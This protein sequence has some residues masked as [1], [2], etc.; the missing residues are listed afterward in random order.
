MKISARPCKLLA[1][2]STLLLPVTVPLHAAIYTGGTGNWSVG[3]NWDTGT[4]PDG[5]GAVVS[6][7]GSGTVTV[8]QDLSSVTVGTISLTGNSVFT[9]STGLNGMILN[10]DGTGSGVAVIENA[11]TTTGARLAITSG[12]S[13]SY[14]QIADDLQIKQSNANS[15]ASAASGN[16]AIQIVERIIGTGSIT[17]S[18]VLNDLNYGTI[19]MGG[20]TTTAGTYTG[21]ITVAK[22]ALSWTSN[23]A[24]GST[25]GIT[26]GS[27]GGGDVSFVSNNTAAT[28]AAAITV[29]SG[30]GGTT[31]LGSTLA[32][33]N[34]NFSGSLT[35]NQNLTVISQMTTADTAGVAIT[36]AI[37]G[38][39]GLQINGTVKSSGSNIDTAGIVKLSGTN[40]FTG[41]TRVYKGSL[42]LGAASGTNSLALQNSTLNLAS[43]DTGTVGF[44]LTNSTTITSATLGGLSGTRDL[45][46]QNIATTSAAVALSVGKNNSDTTYSGALTGSGSL[47]KIG[48]GTLTLNGQ[49]TYTGATTISA[50]TLLL[51]TGSSIASSSSVKVNSASAKLAGTGLA[52]AIT[53]SAG[54]ISPGNGGI[55][56]LS[57]SS[58]A[59]TG[60]AALVFDLSTTGNTSDLLALSGALTKVGSGSYTFDFTGGLAGQVYTLLTFGSSSG[61][62]S[63]DF[64][65]TGLDGTFSLSGSS[66]TFTVVPE[67]ATWT[68]V[69]AGLCCTI[70]LRR[71]RR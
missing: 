59:W 39:G 14:L 63:S 17:F 18:N 68:L 47:T 24:F 22:G 30:T 32:T 58:L 12:L 62:S 53:L 51:G 50:G 23:A 64:S 60:G 52:S 56:T 46:L 34:Q 29:A 67:P 38:A 16:Y 71:R 40:T 36:G 26:L 2:V 48:T 13:P 20:G 11:A 5:I 49:S 54:S 4:Y 55:G 37:S 33:G 25:S 8:T 1:A 10:Q 9:I 15:T 69:V 3:T 35:L 42:L 65:T 28:V 43:G 41:D 7:T 61:F 66:L 44:G 19:C 6:R 21:A 57:A 27:A 31:V 70:F 45:S